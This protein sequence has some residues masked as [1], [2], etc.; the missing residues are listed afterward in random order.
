MAAG[1]SSSP[2]CVGIDVGTGSTKAI[3]CD[4]A[5]KILAQASSPHSIQSPRPGWNEQSPEQWW[6]ATDKAVR[7]ALAHIGKHRDRVRGIGLSGQMHGSVFLDSSGRAIRPALL[8]NDQRTAGQCDDITAAVGGGTSLLA[9]TRNRALPGFTAPKLLWLRNNEPESYRKLRT[10]L[11]PKDYIG[12]KLTGEKM[13]DVTDASGTLLL[14]VARRRWSSHVV[15]KLEIDRSILPPVLESQEVAGQLLASVARA[16]RLRDG[17]VVAAGAGDQPAAALGLGISQEGLISATLGTSG[18]AFACADSPAS[19]PGGLLQSFC[20]AIPGKWCVFGCMLSAGA[21]IDWL[22]KTLFRDGKQ[23][24]SF[25]ALCAR[26]SRVPAGSRGLLFLPYLEG[27]RCPHS[28]PLSR[29]GWL[30]LNRHHDLACMTRAVFEG[31]TFG[32]S[33]QLVLFR[34]M[35]IAVSEVRCAGGGAK[36][37]FWLQ[38]Q[39]DT[40]GVPIATTA[41]TEASAMGAAILGGVACGIWP[42]VSGACSA[43][44]RVRKRVSPQR[45]SA[46][47]YSQRHSVYR[48]LYPALKPTFPAMA[49]DESRA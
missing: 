19:N 14:D 8:W 31:V 45:K 6:R 25:E 47:L 37:R 27:E 9:R 44:V 32:M 10:L 21:A 3:V 11:L 39:A 16:W 41:T 17:V 1:S 28:D 2:L 23:K 46:R 12:M 42:S 49:I 35:G 20:H 18:V 5:G 24:P 48:S 34:E 4:G 29:A 40:Y 43:V 30:G 26:A 33:D 22:A 38:L 13:T 7:K 36:S 15:D